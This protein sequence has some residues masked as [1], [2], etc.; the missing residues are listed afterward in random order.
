M[1]PIRSKHPGAVAQ[2]L[3]LVLFSWAGAP[4]S[5]VCDNGGEFYE[6]VPAAEGLRRAG[7][8]RGGGG[9]MACASELAVNG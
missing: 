4:N 5:L 6:E 7:L 3:E 1:A 9:R 2:A 8:V